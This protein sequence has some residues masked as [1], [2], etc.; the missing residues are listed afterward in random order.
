MASSSHTSS[1][2]HGQNQISAT[3]PIQLH[4]QLISTKLTDENHLI[5][6]QQVLTTVRGHGLEGFLDGSSLPPTRFIPGAEEDLLQVNPEYTS[7]ERQDQLLA[8]WLL[9]SLSESILISVVGMH[10]SSQIWKSLES[11]FSTQSKARTMH[12]RIQLQNLKKGSMSIREYVNKVKIC[13]DTLAAGGH[14]V[15]EQDQ[16]MHVLSGLSSDKSL[17]PNQQATSKLISL[18]RKRELPRV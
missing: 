1:S 10:T 16:I 4:N 7:W 11:S 3:T 14:V 5:W 12:Y 18:K 6:R 8:S 17:N 9:S 2:G 13:C 15:T